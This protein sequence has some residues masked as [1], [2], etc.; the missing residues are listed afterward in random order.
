MPCYAIPADVKESSHLISGIF[1]RLSGMFQNV[2]NSYSRGESVVI[3]QPRLKVPNLIDKR[4]LL[5]VHG[6]F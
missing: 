2:F 3:Q 6:I 1:L 5:I 4:K